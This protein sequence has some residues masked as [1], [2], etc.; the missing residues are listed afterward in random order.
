MPPQLQHAAAGAGD[1]GRIHEPD[2]Y[3]QKQKHD[4]ME[5]VQQQAAEHADCA[6]LRLGRNTRQVSAITTKKKSGNFMAT[7]VNVRQACMFAGKSSECQKRDAGAK[8]QLSADFMD[9]QKIK[10]RAYQTGLRSTESVLQRRVA[11]NDRLMVA[12]CS[13]LVEQAR[14][15]NEGGGGGAAAAGAGP[16]GAPVVAVRPAATATATALH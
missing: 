12:Q 8:R 5:P 16:R 3:K 15:L 13:R 2:P 10:Y 14:T 11:Q 9:V 1:W 7:T 4:I 6:S